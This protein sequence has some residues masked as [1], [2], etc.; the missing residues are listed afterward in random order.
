MERLDVTL[1]QIAV[2]ES[3]AAR[4]LD[5]SAAEFRRLVAAGALPG[6]VRIGPNERWRVD[7]LQAILS[8]DARRPDTDDME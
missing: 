7:Q 4:L 1:R 6:P 5:M 2:R 3:T 8:G